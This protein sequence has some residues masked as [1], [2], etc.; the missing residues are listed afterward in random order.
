MKQYYALISEYNSKFVVRIFTS[1]TKV[2]ISK[3]EC[4]NYEL[5]IAYADGYC[6]E[7]ISYIVGSS[8]FIKKLKDEDHLT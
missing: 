3:R 4:S 2:L 5:A 6:D 8:P 7:T 1:E